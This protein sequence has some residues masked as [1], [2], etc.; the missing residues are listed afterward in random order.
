MAVLEHDGK[1][2][3]LGP[4]TTVGS[5][6]QANHRVQGQDLAARHFVIRVD[7]AGSATVA[8][9]GDACV[10]SLNGV[11]IPRTGAPLHDGAVISAGQA[12]FIYGAGDRA[13]RP[14]PAPDA[15]GFLIDTT[16]RRAYSLERR[17]VQIGRDAGAGIVLKDPTVSRFHADIR[18]E[19]GGHVLYSSGTTGT[20]INEEPVS[21]PR[22][23]SD[24]NEIRIGRMTLVFTSSAPPG[25]KVHTPAGT[26][27][28]SVSRRSTQVDMR[29][30]RE[31]SGGRSILT[32]LLSGAVVVLLGTLV[33]LLMR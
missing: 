31:T 14:L 2:L 8:P 16:A 26:E 29:A 28:S 1:L 17:T 7:P 32:P 22:L 20:Y 3:A 5:G 9:T 18:S 30:Y 11:Q 25:M 27:E 10:V 23:L 12:R 15:L 24:G 6:A 21:R 4:D 33:V 19:A 13:P